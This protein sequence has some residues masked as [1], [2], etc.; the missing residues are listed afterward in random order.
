ML[1]GV[2]AGDVRPPTANPLPTRF[3]AFLPTVPRPPVRTIYTLLPGKELY[4][5]S[6]FLVLLIVDGRSA[7]PLVTLVLLTCDYAAG[8]ILYSLHVL[9]SMCHFLAPLLVAHGPLS[10]LMISPEC[11]NSPPVSFSMSSSCLPF[12]TLDRCNAPSFVMA[13]GRGRSCLK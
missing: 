8:L 3:T 2:N 10:P 9:M 11:C 4:V 7:C 12:V 1:H 6:C 13:H 5:L